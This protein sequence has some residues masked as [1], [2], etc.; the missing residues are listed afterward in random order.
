MIPNYCINMGVTM[1]VTM[2]GIIMLLLSVISVYII[3]TLKSNDTFT[4]AA[5]LMNQAL[6]TN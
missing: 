3:M 4:L 5:K 2:M 1:G 6:K